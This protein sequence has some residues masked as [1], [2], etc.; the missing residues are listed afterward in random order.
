MVDLVQ[1]LEKTEFYGKKWVQQHRNQAFPLLVFN[2]ILT[3]A[4]FFLRK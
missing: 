3:I 4:V 2:E 1:L